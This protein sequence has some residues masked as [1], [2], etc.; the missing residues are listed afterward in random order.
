MV[1]II[2]EV[3]LMYVFMCILVDQI[4]MLETI[5]VACLKVASNL[6]FELFSRFPDVKVMAALG[7]V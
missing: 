2:M 3:L 5:K 6:C 7:M 4:V 1:S